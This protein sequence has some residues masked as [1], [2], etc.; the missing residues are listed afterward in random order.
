MRSVTIW[1]LTFDYPNQDS[2]SVSLNWAFVPNWKK[3]IMFMTMG[4]A[5]RLTTGSIM[6]QANGGPQHKQPSSSRVHLLGTI[7]NFETVGSLKSL[8]KL[9]S[10]YV[11]PLCCF[12]FL[13]F[14]SYNHLFT[15]HPKYGPFTIVDLKKVGHN[16]DFTANKLTLMGTN[17]KKRNHT[18]P[19]H[20]WGTTTT[21]GQ[22]Q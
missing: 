4:R 6:P 3:D 12:S 14:S 13:E 21:I 15:I 18:P 16:P 1:P 20:F 17:W 22:Q 7:F 5:D 11:S 8:F 9:I 19:P 10:M 2:K